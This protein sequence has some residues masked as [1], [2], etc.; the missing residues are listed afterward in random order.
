MVAGYDQRILGGDR[1]SIG[2]GEQGLDQKFI[3]SKDGMLFVNTV[4]RADGG[5]GRSTERRPGLP[6]MMLGVRGNGGHP[7]R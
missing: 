3:V 6:L 7:N 2:I 4:R 5:V 1:A